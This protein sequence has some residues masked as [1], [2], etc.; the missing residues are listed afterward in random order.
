M[1]SNSAH[2]THIDSNIQWNK[3][4]S[5]WNLVAPPLR[6]SYEDLNFIQRECFPRLQ[7]TDSTPN[8]VA[9]LG[10]TPEIALL[11]WPEDTNIIGIDSSPLMIDQVWP[12]KQ[13]QRGR[14]ICGN[15]RE[16]DL[17]DSSCDMVV[18]D[19]S[20]VLLD[21][22]NDYKV[23][24]SEIFRVLKP[25]GFLSL[26]IFL[27][28]DQPENVKHVF[29]QLKSSS[30]G[31]FHVFKWRLAMAL[32]N[33][34]ENELTTRRVLEC[35]QQEIPEP[36]ELMN[37]L[38][39]SIDVLKTINVY[40]KSESILTFPTLRQI[41]DLFSSKFVEEVCNFPTYELGERCPSILFQVRK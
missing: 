12:R 38:G 11:P 21:Y 22:Q 28:L 33:N 1:N 17:P 19:G 7:N 35:W 9:I 13:V 32:Q 23:V 3:Y 24:L 37:E 5:A 31:N 15:W 14:A 16:L 4:S 27:N 20:F 2:T 40:E 39:W 10:V 30:I 34:V 36:E 25:Q 41:R 18:G 8:Q 6:P 26:R 29:T